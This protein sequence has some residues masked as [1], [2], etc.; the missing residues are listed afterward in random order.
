MVCDMEYVFE[1][2]II[3]WVQGE[4]GED[5]WV[6]QNFNSDDLKSEPSW[7]YMKDKMTK[8]QSELTVKSLVRQVLALSFLTL[9]F[10]QVKGNQTMHKVWMLTDKGRDFL[11]LRDHSLKLPEPIQTIKLLHKYVYTFF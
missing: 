3:S 1:S 8:V 6:W 11:E 4:Q 5:C 10:R 2:K 7:S 9:E